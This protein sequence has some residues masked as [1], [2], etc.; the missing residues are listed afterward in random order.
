MMT[1]FFSLR[2]TLHFKH[3]LIAEK[4]GE[5]RRFAFWLVLKLILFFFSGIHRV[6]PTVCGTGEGVLCHRQQPQLPPD[7]EVLAIFFSLLF[8]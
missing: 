6:D 4:S 7:G 8:D 2:E 5:K 1:L 3:M